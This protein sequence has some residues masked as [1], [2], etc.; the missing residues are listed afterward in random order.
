MFNIHDFPIKFEDN[1]IKNCKGKIILNFSKR[2]SREKIIQF[3]IES[4]PAINDG[5]RVYKKRLTKTLDKPLEESIELIKEEMFKQGY[6]PSKGI[7][8]IE[9]NIISKNGNKKINFNKIQINMEENKKDVIKNLEGLLIKL[10]NAKSQENL[11]MENK[12]IAIKDL[13]KLLNW[14]WESIK[15]DINIKGVLNK[16]QEVWYT[17]ITNANKKVKYPLISITSGLFRCYIITLFKSVNEG[18]I[19]KQLTGWKVEMLQKEK[20]TFDMKI[21]FLSLNQMIKNKKK[22]EENNSNKEIK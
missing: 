22:E 14:Y 2:L 7:S 5:R 13:I 20:F 9:Y 10:L 4:I 3:I 16:H 12:E 19:L 11:T 1:C 21:L 6:I 8:E 15:K 18:E 17:A